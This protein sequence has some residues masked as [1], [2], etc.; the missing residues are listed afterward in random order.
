MANVNNPYG[1]RLIDSEGKEFRVH[2]YPKVSAGVIADGDPVTVDATGAV[3][4]AAAG[5]ALLGVAVEYKASG[6]VGP[7]AVCDDPEAVFEIQA[8]ANALA[9]DV[10]ANANV[11]AATYDS[12]LNRSKFALDSASIGTGATLQLKIMG[13]STIDDN[14]YGSYARLKVKINNHKLKGGTGTSGV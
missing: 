9:A 14:A 5:D 4:L 2:R 13:L 1:M 8:S 12:L 6:D 3:A 11:V 10:F 7:I